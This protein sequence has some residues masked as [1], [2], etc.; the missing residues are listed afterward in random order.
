LAKLAAVISTA[1]PVNSETNCSTIAT[2]INDWIA[3]RPTATADL[4]SN[5]LHLVII[6]S[7]LEL[8]ASLQ[9]EPGE[10]KPLKR[11]LLKSC[12]DDSSDFVKDLKNV[13]IDDHRIKMSEVCSSICEKTNVT[14]SIQNSQGSDHHRLSE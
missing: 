6:L 2:R 1:F 7:T 10:L 3:D 14:L 12:G 9:I 5:R 4:F 8:R 13:A 11:E